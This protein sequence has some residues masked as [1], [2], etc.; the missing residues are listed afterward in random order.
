L[1]FRAAVV[2]DFSGAPDASLSDVEFC[3]GIFLSRN[4]GQLADLLLTVLQRRQ[5]P[6]NHRPLGLA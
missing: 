1:E 4:L 3:G 5:L 6:R 2:Q